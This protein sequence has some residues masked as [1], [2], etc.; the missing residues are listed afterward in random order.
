MAKTVEEEILNGRH[1]AYAVT[2][3]RVTFRSLA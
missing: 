2:L 3:E 1:A